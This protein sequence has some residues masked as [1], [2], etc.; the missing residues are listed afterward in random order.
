MN[1][2]PLSYTASRQTALTCQCLCW[3]SL[4]ELKGKILL[5]AKKISGPGDCLDETLT[6]DVSDEEDI[7]NDEAESLPTD[8]PPAECL[9]HNGKVRELDTF[10]IP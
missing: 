6:D 10:R 3:C 7:A 8:D 1:W 4:Q 2:W 9:N 5:K